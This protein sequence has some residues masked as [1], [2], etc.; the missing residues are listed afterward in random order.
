MIVRENYS[1]FL[2]LF[3]FFSKQLLIDLN[4]YKRRLSEGFEQILIGYRNDLIEVE[5]DI[6]KDPKYSL[7]KFNKFLKVR[8]LFIRFSFHLF[9]YN[10]LAVFA[11]IRI[12]EPNNNS[13]H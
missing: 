13:N 6:I 8:H 5:K 4:S 9:S 12:L 7:I 11:N 2:F 1:N 3:I 10:L